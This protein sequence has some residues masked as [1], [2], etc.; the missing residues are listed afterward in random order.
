MGSY[1]SSEGMV[2]EIV[3]V[4]DKVPIFYTGDDLVHEVRNLARHWV[5][6]ESITIENEGESQVFS[7]EMLMMDHILW[8]LSD[9]PPWNPDSM[10]LVVMV[11]NNSNS[12][13]HQ[14]MQMNVNEFDIDND[15][16]V[17]RDDNCM[18]E[19]NEMEAHFCSF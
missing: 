19:S 18:F 17:N 8:Q 14:S 6:N 9:D 5:G 1:A 4:E 2:V 10:K 7:G 16:V 13:I 3:F 15:G 11:Q 12:D